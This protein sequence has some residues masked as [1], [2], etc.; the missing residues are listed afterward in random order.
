MTAFFK[1]YYGIIFYW[2]IVSFILLYFAPK[3]SKYY[4]DQ[5]IKLFKTIYLIPTLIVFFGLF[6]AGLFTFW[7][8]KTKSAKKATFSFLVT[9]LIFVFIFFIFQ[10]VFLGLALFANRQ[11]TK[12]KITKI[13]KASFM[14]GADHSKSNFYLYDSSTGQIINDKKLV[15]KLYRLELK[16]NNN[17]AVSMEIG[18]FGIAFKAQPFDDKY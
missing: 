14:V 5:D 12:G 15:N 13:Y 11:M 9:A 1:K 8:I 3:Q 7:L 6:A 16:Q 2:I 10:N 4:L 18:L 17:I